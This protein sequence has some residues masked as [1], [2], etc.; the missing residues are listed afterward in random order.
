MTLKAEIFECE[1]CGSEFRLEREKNAI[2]CACAVADHAET[3]QGV[4][5]AIFMRI[6]RDFV[7]SG[8]WRIFDSMRGQPNSM[9]GVAVC[10]DCKKAVRAALDAR[11]PKVAGQQTAEKCW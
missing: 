6:R 9:Y 1:V 11:D 5:I 2:K 4:L 3:D 7:E 8:Q 10:D